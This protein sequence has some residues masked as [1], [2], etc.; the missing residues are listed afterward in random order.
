MVRPKTIHNKAFCYIYSNI[1]KFHFRPNFP[2][3]AKTIPGTFPIPHFA[4]VKL[5]HKLNGPFKISRCSHPVY[6][7]E[8]PTAKRV[9]IKTVTRDKLKRANPL[10]KLVAEHNECN[11]VESRSEPIEPMTSDSDDND[12]VEPRYNLRSCRKHHSL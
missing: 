11:P 2:F 3:N 8:V 1:A 4:P 12:E 6:S 10:Q 7:V 5:A 9:I